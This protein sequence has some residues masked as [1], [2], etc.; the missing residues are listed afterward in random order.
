[1]PACRV[2]VNANEG[3]S[4]VPDGDGED[5]L[6]YIRDF[7]SLPP[8]KR[9]SRSNVIEEKTRAHQ[10]RGYGGRGTWE[11]FRTT[12]L[13][14]HQWLAQKIKRSGED[15]PPETWSILDK[16]DAPPGWGALDEVDAYLEDTDACG[17]ISECITVRDRDRADGI[18]GF[19][20]YSIIL[21]AETMERKRKRTHK[22]VSFDFT[23][24]IQQIYVRPAYRQKKFGLALCFGLSERLKNIVE[25]GLSTQPAAHAFRVKDITLYADCY[26]EE[27]YEWMASLEA[28]VDFWV[29]SAHCGHALES[30]TVTGD[31]GY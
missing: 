19:V 30:A 15:S 21:Y 9:W 31:F 2:T 4:L 20:A 3:H 23:V 25:H 6:A 26:S 24:D 1:M 28:E 10:I 17:G 8:S 14:E 5:H 27:G 16:Q 18:A 22:T 29:A 12:A 11:R 13:N 7:L